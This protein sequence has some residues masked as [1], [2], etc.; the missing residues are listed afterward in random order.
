MYMYVCCV[1]SKRLGVSEQPSLKEERLLTGSL[2]AETG[3]GGEETRGGWEDEEGGGG[4]RWGVPV[5]GSLPA[6]PN[7][8]GN[9]RQ[10][11]LTEQTNWTSSWEVLSKSS[12]STH[13]NIKTVCQIQ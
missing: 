3:E 6:Y 11:L 7:F 13:F 9:S 8:F 4:G 5:A 2:G 1:Q 12:T 10:R